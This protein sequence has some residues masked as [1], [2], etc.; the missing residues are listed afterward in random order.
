MLKAQAVSALASFGEAISS[1][2]IVNNVRKNV[3]ENAQSARPHAAVAF[4]NPVIAPSN[5][6]RQKASEPMLIF[7][8]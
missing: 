6:F 1:T 8:I 7:L 3:V 4:A 2:A 5:S